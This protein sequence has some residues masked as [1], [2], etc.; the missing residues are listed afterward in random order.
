MKAITILEPWASL[1]ACGAKKIETR[2]WATSY[3]GKIA[4][5]AAKQINGELMDMA[6][7]E[8]IRS[9]LKNNKGVMKDQKTGLLFNPGYVVAVADLADVQAVTA[10]IF[11]IRTGKAHGAV[12]GKG[13]TL[14]EIRG[15]EYFYGKYAVGGY[16][17]ILENVQR[18]EPVPAKGQQRIWNLNVPAVEL[19]VWHS[20]FFGGEGDDRL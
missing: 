5:H 9:T 1:I 6:G 17:W 4:I 2:S 15:N 18:V 19:A 20:D 8:P 16:A 11:D 14:R 12:I 3:R 13:S 7:E 10:N